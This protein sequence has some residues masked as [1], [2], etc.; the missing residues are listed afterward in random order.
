MVSKMNFFQHLTAFIGVVALTA[1]T[2]I[3]PLDSIVGD[4]G[5]PLSDIAKRTDVIYYGLDLEILP[6]SKSIVGVGRSQFLIIQ[7]TSQVELKLD[8]RFDISKISIDESTA[9]YER[10]GGIITINLGMTKTI[11]D[12]VNIAV[13][14]SGKPHIALRA[15]WSGGFVWSETENGIPWIATAVQGEGCD[16]FWPC[17]T[18][19]LI[20]PR[21]WIFP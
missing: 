19:L 9:S 7:D 21:A 1:C 17:N 8:S 2:S 12:L 11:G 18:I 6:Q 4:T 10:I 13:H 3:A 16:L 5:Q 14:Y 20:K 15:P